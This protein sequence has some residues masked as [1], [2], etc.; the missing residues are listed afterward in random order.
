MN[1]N[2]PINTNFD[3]KINKTILYN[4]TISDFK[5]A[6]LGLLQFF[7]AQTRIKKIKGY[8]SIHFIESKII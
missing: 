5:P 8:I 6:R 4:S 3:T 1:N 7:D 2:K